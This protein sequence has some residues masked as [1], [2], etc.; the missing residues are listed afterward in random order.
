MQADIRSAVP[1]T[2]PTTK[3]RISIGRADGA[4]RREYAPQKLDRPHTR[5][6]VALRK[7]ISETCSPT[8]C[9]QKVGRKWAVCNSSENLFM[10]IQKQPHL[11]CIYTRT[12]RSE[13]I[14]TDDSNGRSS[15][16]AKCATVRKEY[17]D[18]GSIYHGP[19]RPAARARVAVLHPFLNLSIDTPMVHLFKLIDLSLELLVWY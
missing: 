5:A 12:E 18:Q 15:L 17:S 6:S 16:Q 7:A 9:S 2:A 10:C 8:L 11:L 1:Q 14:V 19:A 3:N 4:S 13:Q